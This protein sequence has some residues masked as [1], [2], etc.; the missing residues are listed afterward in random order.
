M[1]RENETSRDAIH[2]YESVRKIAEMWGISRDQFVA[3]WQS[4]VHGE[5]N[6]LEREPAFST[7][8]KDTRG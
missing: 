3:D 7:R 8:R 5:K 2:A 6:G 4:H 1:T